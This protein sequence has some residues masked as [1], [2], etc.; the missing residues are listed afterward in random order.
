MDKNFKN[1]KHKYATVQSSKISDACVTLLNNRTNFT[2]S[3]V[4]HNTPEHIRPK[5]EW[6][7]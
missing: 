7:K 2:L 3:G 4:N 1:L 6:K 5:E